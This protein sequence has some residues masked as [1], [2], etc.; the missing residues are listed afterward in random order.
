MFKF[1]NFLEAEL[2]TWGTVNY[3]QISMTKALKS[4]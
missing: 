1:K 2:L 3:Q 4:L